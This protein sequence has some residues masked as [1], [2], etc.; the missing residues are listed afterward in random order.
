MQRGDSLFL[1]SSLMTRHCLAVASTGTGKSNFLN[2]ILKQQMMRGGGVI[3]IDGKNNEDAINEFISLAIQHDRWHD[4]RIINIDNAR[5]SNTYNPLLRGDIEELVNRVMMLVPQDGKNAFFRSQASSA[6]RAIIGLLKHMQLPFTFEDLRQIMSRESGLLWLRHHAPQD[7]REYHDYQTFLDSLKPDRPGSVLDERKRQFAFGDLLGKI[8]TYAMGENVR[9]VVN[10]YNPEV[11]ILNAM[12]S[13]QLVYV[14]LPTMSKGEAA[15]DFA[16]ILL[17]DIQTAVGQLQQLPVSERP[18]PTFLILMDEFSSYAAPFLTT[19][20]EQARS[21]NVCLFPFVQTISSLSD[22]GKGLSDDFKQ[23]IVGN[24]WNKV[25]FGLRDYESAEALSLLAGQ[26]PKEEKTVSYSENIGMKGGDD[27]V[28]LINVG[29]RGKS[30]SQS[31][32]VKYDT[33]IRADEFMNLP[34][35]QSFFLCNQGV[36]KLKIPEVSVRKE[37]GKIQF[38]R[39]RM[40]TRQGLNM[41]KQLE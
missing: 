10:V 1:P 6:L 33:V 4:V 22:G 37:S 20:F 17:A 23:K 38:P 8:S 13:N 39:F 30:T 35:G 16:K 36:Y 12:R 18:V 29:S 24:T 34:V 31:V 14:G 19:L 40:P 32:T 28:S 25:V 2:L 41:K 9:D 11:D 5:M 21:T 27:A 26:A 15:N 3:H 7:N